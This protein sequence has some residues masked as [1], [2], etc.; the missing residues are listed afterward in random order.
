MVSRRRIELLADFRY[1]AFVPRFGLSQ[2]EREAA[3]PANVAIRQIDRWCSDLT[4]WP[5][6]LELW[7][8]IEGSTLRAPT[9]PDVERRVKPALQRALERGE[10]VAVSATADRDPTLATPGIRILSPTPNTVVVMDDTPR[11]PA[12]DIVAKVEQGLLDLTNTT[13]LEWSAEVR[14]NPRTAGDRHGPNRDFIVS[15]SGQTQDG[16]ISVAFN[17]VMAGQLAVSLRATVGGRIVS[18]TLALTVVARNPTRTAVQAEIGDDLM[19]RVA[20]H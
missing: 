5:K 1:W 18:A 11:I 20:C 15:A 17:G 8:A 12:I 2:T 19:Q 6:M 9:V 13:T 3:V 16:R 7:E 10:W 4:T 14:H